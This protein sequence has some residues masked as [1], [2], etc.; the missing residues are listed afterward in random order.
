[1][2]SYWKSQPRK[3]CEVCKCWLGDNKASIEFHERGKSHQEKKRKQL[4][5]IRKKGVQQAKDNAKAGTYLKKMEEAA[6]RKYLQDLK[7]QGIK[8]NE[9][10]YLQREQST[11]AAIAK[12]AYNF[13]SN[14][15]GPNKAK[16]V[17]YAKIAV[18]KVD[19][20]S[21]SKVENSTSQNIATNS[22]SSSSQPFGKWTVVERTAESPDESH[23]YSAARSEI[24]PLEFTEKRVAVGT[25]EDDAGGPVAFKKRKFGKRNIRSKDN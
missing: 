24:K 19:K 23:R 25:S 16:P 8:V 1:M 22:T 18:V 13:S 5:Q 14:P 17:S 6:K 11:K 20:D 2:A 10:E 15:P 7:E 3:F 21:N 4:D 9:E 12:P